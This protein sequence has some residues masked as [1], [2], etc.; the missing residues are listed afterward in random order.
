[1]FVKICG[2]TNLEDGLAAAKAG[3]RAL[4]FI[5]YAKSPRGVT[6]DQVEPF[7]ADLP[8]D[9]WR[10]GV[11]VD[12]KPETIRAIADRVGL[13]IAQLHGAESPEQHPEGLRIWKAFRVRNGLVP[14][15]DYPAEAVL[16]DGPGS[17]QTFDWGVAARVSRPVVLSGGLTPENVRAAIAAT[18]P[19]GVDICSGIESSPGRKDHKRMNQFIEAALRS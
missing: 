19:W 12:E 1:M 15:P 4:G 16:L 6:A 7:V 14:N 13:D 3:A 17:G 18:S 5:F 11:F 10:V 9:V 8:K 2:I